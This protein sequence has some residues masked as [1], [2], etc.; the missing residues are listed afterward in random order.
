MNT[1]THAIKD[2]YAMGLDPLVLEDLVVEKR[3]QSLWR[4]T[5][6]VDARARR[7]SSD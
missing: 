7:L 5:E 1:P 6:R 4:A 3:A 2:F